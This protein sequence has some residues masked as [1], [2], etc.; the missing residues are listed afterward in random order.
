MCDVNAEKDEIDSVEI[1]YSH[2][3]VESLENQR[4]YYE[5]ELKSTLAI[6]MQLTETEQAEA[7]A[8]ELHSVKER[9]QKALQK[10][11]EAL[12]QFETVLARLLSN[13]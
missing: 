2:L 4:H 3:L 9:E 6:S 8:H 1:Q 7:N 13:C 12:K 10:Q 11:K 5:G